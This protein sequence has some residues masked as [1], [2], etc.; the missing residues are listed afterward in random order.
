MFLN[1]KNIASRFFC[2]YTKTFLAD[3]FLQSNLNNYMLSHKKVK[4]HEKEIGWNII[5]LKVFKTKFQ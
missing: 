1:G 3:F 2:V 5:V 4:N